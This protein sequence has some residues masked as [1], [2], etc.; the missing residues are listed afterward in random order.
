MAKKA[1]TSNSHSAG[2]G[3]AS[4][5]T[6][7]TTGNVAYSTNS[8]NSNNTPSVPANNPFYYPPPG[9][10]P[11]LP[12]PTQMAMPMQYYPSYTLPTNNQVSTATNNTFVANPPSVNSAPWHKTAAVRPSYSTAVAPA[13]AKV[14]IQVSRQPAPVSTGNGVRPISVPSTVTV[15][16]KWSAPMKAYVERC[17]ATCKSPAEK[18]AM[19]EILRVK[20]K[21]VL[22]E[23]RMNG[24]AWER[25]A[26]PAVNKTPSAK[27]V[28][29]PHQSPLKGSLS[30]SKGSPDDSKLLERQKRFAA[31]ER[32]FRLQQ[33]RNRLALQNVSIADNQADVPDWDEET[34][35]GT[36]Q[37][38][39]KP[40]LRLTSA[41]DPATVRPL[42]VLKRALEWLKEKWRTGGVEYGFICDQFKSLRQD[43]TVQRIKSDFTVAVYEIHARIAIEQGDWGEYNQCQTQLKQ[44]YRSG[45][46]GSEPEFLAYRLLYLLQCGDKLGVN[47]FLQQLLLLQKPEGPVEHALA[48]QEAVNVG[49]HARL[50]KLYRLAP[51]MGVYLMDLLVQRERLRAFKA[52]L[53]GYR[54]SLS[55][56]LLQSTLGFDGD[57]QGFKEWLKGL[58]VIGT[59]TSLDCK[60]ISSLLIE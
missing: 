59:S 35:V 2:N 21:S 42:P 19:E 40:Y 23:G 28:G 24:I 55:L 38:L 17:F 32:E 9:M 52:M 22:G 10:Y 20:I 12:V 51:N 26:I 16:S 11:Y 36:C 31:D 13:S 53:R 47:E 56:A 41:P 3:V 29:T 14:N 46:H 60:E 15:T 48:V 5:G 57:D 39:E 45:L 54:P 49:S 6:V 44:L 1:K 4:S 27:S 58:G 43:M 25:E 34:I 30:D 50:F 18:D 37:K 7:N 8:N 33:A